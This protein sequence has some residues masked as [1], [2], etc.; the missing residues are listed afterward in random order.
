MK[1]ENYIIKFFDNLFSLQ[2]IF[3][4]ASYYIYIGTQSMEMNN[5]A[6]SLPFD[7]QNKENSTISI[8]DDDE[9]SSS[10][11][12]MLSNSISL[13]LKSPVFLSMNINNE[14]LLANENFISFLEEEICKIALNNK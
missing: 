13:K 8:F 14:N 5:L 9:L 11:N 10:Y 6:L 4:N 3:L 1:N 7:Q 12:T 2:I